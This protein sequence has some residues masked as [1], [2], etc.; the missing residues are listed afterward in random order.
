MK[1]GDILGGK[2]GD[3]KEHTLKLRK[4]LGVIN[5]ELL[6]VSEAGNFYSLDG[7]VHSKSKLRAA[8]YEVLERPMKDFSGLKEGDILQSTVGMYIKIMARVGD[9]LFLS[10]QADTREEANTGEREIKLLEELVGS[11]VPDEVKEGIRRAAAKLSPKKTVKTAHNVFGGMI[12]VAEA[13][14]L[15]FDLVTD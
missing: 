15:D 2:A 1:I 7:E 13:E 14:M 6:L 5:D 12:S 9:V 11:G 3:K 10:D 8:G 4:V